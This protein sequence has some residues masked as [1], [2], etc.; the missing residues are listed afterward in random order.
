MNLSRA[1]VTSA[2]LAAALFTFANGLQAKPDYSKKEKKGCTTCH[3]SAKSKELNEA[4]KHYQ[5]HKTLPPAA[6]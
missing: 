3:T 1:L 2:A 5:T 6:K 4:G